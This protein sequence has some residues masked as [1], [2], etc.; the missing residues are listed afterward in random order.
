MNREE[1]KKRIMEI[2]LL[3]VVRASSSHEAKLAVEAVY[4]GWPGSPGSVSVCSSEAMP[5]PR[6]AALTPARNLSSVRVSISRR[7]NSYSSKAK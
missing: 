6:N 7:W 4:E 1:I 2:G 5:R 3:P